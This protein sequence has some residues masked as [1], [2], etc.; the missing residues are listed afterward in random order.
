[1]TSVADAFLIAGAIGIRSAIIAG[2]FAGVAL[3]R[4]NRCG[5]INIA[6]RAGRQITHIRTGFVNA[7]VAGAFLIRSALAVGGAVSGNRRAGYARAVGTADARRI[8]RISRTARFAVPQLRAGFGGAGIVDAFL[9]A[10]A[11]AV[12]QAAGRVSGASVVAG[13]IAR[14]ARHGDALVVRA[15]L[16]ACALAVGRAV[17]GNGRAGHARAVRAADAR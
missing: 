17:S 10:G 14:S 7:S 1:M 11:V 12:G 5:I 16:I 4:S 8:R 2:S 15:F 9:R 13:V 6:C 3:V